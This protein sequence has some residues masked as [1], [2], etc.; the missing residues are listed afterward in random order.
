MLKRVI[1][2]KA[3]IPE[4][5]AEYYEERDG[6]FFLAVDE[7]L[8]LK[9]ALEKEKAHVKKLKDMLSQYDGVDID[10]VKAL[11]SKA[12][13]DEER[14]KLKTGDIE[15]VVKARIEK[16]TRDF[17]S[18]LAAETAAKKGLMSRTLQAELRNAAL[19]NGVIQHAVDD[20]VMRGLNV[21]TVSDDGSI[22]SMKDNDVVLGKD[23][24]SPY[25]VNEWLEELKPN[26]PH[27]FGN[28]NSGGGAPGN[29]NPS[30]NVKTLTRAQFEGLDPSERMEFVKSKGKVN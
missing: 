10:R 23:G 21:F 25:S 18:K 13:T 30:S 8:E 1:N 6:K 29:K 4:A 27:W 16:Y 2:D 11:L 26:V 22:V 14:E 28:S 15:S 3:D 12:E 9:G 17:E 7:A 24:K 5:L 19:K 20:A